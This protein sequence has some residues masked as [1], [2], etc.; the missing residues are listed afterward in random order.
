YD[1]IHV[2]IDE[3]RQYPVAYLRIPPTVEGGLIVLENKSGRV[4]AMTG[5]FSFALSQLNRVTQTERP[6]GST[7]KPFIY[8]SALNLGYQPN[9]LVPDMPISLPP[10]ARGGHWWSPRNYDG[11][12]RGVVTMR[13]AVERSLNLPTVRVM[14][15]L[16]HTAS[17][18]LDYIRGVTQEL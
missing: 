5:G 14:S 10:I 12:A 2:R 8:L 6:P 11:A 15:Q 18:G 3:E 4:L 17:E 7:L 1:L 13:Q 9:T 16:G